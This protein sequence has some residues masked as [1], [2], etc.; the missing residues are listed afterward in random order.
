MTELEIVVCVVC[1][2]FLLVSSFALLLL[3]WLWRQ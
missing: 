3:W 1:G 2:S